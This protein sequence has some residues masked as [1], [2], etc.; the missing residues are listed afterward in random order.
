MGDWPAINKK[1]DRRLQQESPA[2]RIDTKEE[3]IA[4]VDKLT[5]VITAVLKEELPETKPSPYAR[6]W[7][8][9]ELTDLKKTQNRLSNK[10]YRFRHIPPRCS[11]VQSSC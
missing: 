4:K 2:V 11:Q 6:R 8:T 9:K 1:L 5:E 7:W 3:F 10:V